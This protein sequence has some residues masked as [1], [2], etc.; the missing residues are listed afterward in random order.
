[1]R[2]TIVAALFWSI[3]VL[4]LDARAL[5]ALFTPLRKNLERHL[6]ENPEFL[7]TFNVF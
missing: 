7:P 5:F 2:C 6:H 3:A 4:A 1:M